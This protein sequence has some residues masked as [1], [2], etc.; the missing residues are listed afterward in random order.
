[1]IALTYGL[2]AHWVQN[3]LAAGGCRLETRRVLYR[4][5]TPTIVHDPTRR[6]FPFPV[7]IVLRIIGATDFIQLSHA[8]AEASAPQT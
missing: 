7:R 8:Y 5:S 3:V 6:R 2:Q 1:M 4:L